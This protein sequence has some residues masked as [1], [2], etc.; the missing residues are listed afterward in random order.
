M[1]IAELIFDSLYLQACN[2]VGFL[3]DSTVLYI[4]LG[5]SPL[6][7]GNSLC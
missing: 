2:P 1:K 6:V 3:A 7:F 5:Y 4:H